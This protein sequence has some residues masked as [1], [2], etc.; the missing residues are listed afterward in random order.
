MTPGTGAFTSVTASGVTATGNVTGQNIVATGLIYGTF[1][2]TISSSSVSPTAN[3]ASLETV[4]TTSTNGT[5][6][7][8][9]YSGTTGNLAVQ[10][11]SSLTYNP[12]TGALAATSLT[13]T[14]VASTYVTPTNLSTANAVITGGS[15][16]NTVIG[17]T[18]A[19]AGTF[20]T[21][22]AAT[23]NATTLT[24]T[25]ATATTLSATNFSSSNVQIT[26]GSIT[27]IAMENVTTL[28]ATN[29]STANAVVTGGSVNS[30]PIGATTAST[31]A[32]TTVTTSGAATLNSANVTNGLIVS[33][34]TTATGNATFS[35]GATINSSQA[36]GSDF[37][38]AGVN[39]TNL[40][41]ARA[42]SA[43]DQVVVGNTISA[44]SLT[45]GSKLVVN[46]TDSIQVPVGSN[47]QRP[48]T[49]SGTS[50]ALGQIRVNNQSNVLEY[51]NGASWQGT[52][53]TFTV[54]TSQQLTG[55]GTTT[56]FTLNT[57]T[58][59]AG[60]VISI[61]GVVQLPSIAY[62]I[63]SGTTL[64]FSEAPAA[65][66]IIDV[67]TLVT[68]QT[69]VGVSGPSGYNG[70]NA[71]NDY[72]YVTAGTNAMVNVAAWDVSGAQV[73]MLANVSVGASATTVDTMST[74]TYRSAKYVV[75]VTNGSSYQVMEA[76]LIS[77][78]TTATVTTYGVVSTG[79]SLG[80]LSATQSGTNALLQFTGTA[81]G[82]TVR[83]KKDYILI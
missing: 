41:W 37:K 53:T 17:D 6:Y 82:N 21:A 28:A 4:A 7:P 56:A 49:A 36:A 43:Y 39:T 70:F 26:G 9:F 65:T 72:A 38:A 10:T 35:N 61:N 73:S 55:D 22:T 69:V 25:N 5:Y 12:S 27:G 77:N 47:A 71:D 40:V 68:T 59:T 13:A 66:D 33:G 54:I 63:S 8:A 83:I 42:A 23:V 32:F 19:A 58:T 48:G 79:S 2:G 3:V 60:V 75:Q 15:V 30:T 50:A 52:G 46:S 76:L 57:S 11:N 24:A 62:T 1:A 31:G 78:G 29:F 81:A 80:T 67:R 20:T 14:N 18:T 74:S 34:T 45:T 44:A 64:T 51:Y 16:N